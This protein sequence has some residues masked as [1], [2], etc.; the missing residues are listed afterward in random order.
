LTGLQMVELFTA[1]FR[2]EDGFRDLLTAAQGVLS[3]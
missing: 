3:F 1:R 2:Q